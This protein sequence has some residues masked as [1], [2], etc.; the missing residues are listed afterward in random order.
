MQSNVSAR[1][2][3]QGD[4]LRKYRYSNKK[5]ANIF[6]RMHPEIVSMTDK[7]DFKTLSGNV[8][9][10]LDIADCNSL[11]T[12]QSPDIKSIIIRMLNTT[13]N[14]CTNCCLS[15]NHQRLH[16]TSRYSQSLQTFN[17]DSIELHSD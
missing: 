3:F 16:H 8:G 7:D 11:R 6:R 10:L 9:G 2:E 1:R 17:E 4:L 12:E 13:S 5:N 15:S 14:G